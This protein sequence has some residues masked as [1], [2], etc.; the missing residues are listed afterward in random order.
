MRWRRTTPTFSL[1]G[2]IVRRAL[3]VL[4]EE[5]LLNLMREAKQ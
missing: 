1:S 2:K 5:T 4:R 3:Y